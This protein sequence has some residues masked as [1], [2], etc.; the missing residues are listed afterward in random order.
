MS[1]Q[2]RKQVELENNAF[3]TGLPDPEKNARITGSFF[4]SIESICDFVPAAFAASQFP[5]IQRNQ[6]QGE[7]L[8]PT[9]VSTE[10]LD[11]CLE[12]NTDRSDTTNTAQTGTAVDFL[13]NEKGGKAHLFPN[14]PTCHVAYIGI[15][16]AATGC[17]VESP[18]KRRKLLNGMKNRDR[19]IDDSGIKHSKYNKFHLF[20][21]KEL[22]DSTP[23]ALIIIPILTL[24]QIKGWD[25][26]SAYHAMVLPC[27]EESQFAAKSVMRNVRHCCDETEI[28]TGIEVLCHFIKDIAGSLIDLDHDILDDVETQTSSTNTSLQRWKGLVRELRGDG[29][30]IKIPVL[31]HGLEG[32][33]VKVAKGRFDRILSCLPDPFLVA[34]KGAINFSSFVGT[35]L[36]PACPPPSDESDYGSEEDFDDDRID[37]NR[38]EFNN[39]ESTI[40]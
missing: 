17:F 24:P 22:L 10:F 14:A 4:S 28:Q 15:V 27:G 20:M 36:L 6:A 23:P 21:Q 26:K 8:Y 5:N 9:T 16:Q 1:T 34:V 29:V 11:N 19:R 12:A 38:G 33:E 30:T 40:G 35:K 18:W 37:S 39:G 32:K 2:Y 7:H 25:G 31:K 13:L 3:L